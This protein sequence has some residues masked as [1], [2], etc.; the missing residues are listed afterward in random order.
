MTRRLATLV[1]TAAL[2]AT[3]GAAT[4]GPASAGGL[5]CTNQVCRCYDL[6]V[7]KPCLL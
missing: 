6:V 5:R 4:A 1:L 3:A 7:A 2:T